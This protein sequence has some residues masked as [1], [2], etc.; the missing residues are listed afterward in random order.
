MFCW[1][2]LGSA[3][4]V[5]ITLTCATYLNIEADQVHPFVEM[6]FLDVS[7]PFQQN[8]APCKNGSR[9]VWGTQWLF[10]WPPHST[11]PKPIKHLWDALE[12]QVWSMEAPP[13]NLHNLKR[14]ATDSLEPDTTTYLQRSS[15]IHASNGTKLFWKQKGDLFIIRWVVKVMADQCIGAHMKSVPTFLDCL[16]QIYCLQLPYTVQIFLNPDEIDRI[17]C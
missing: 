13:H 12:K 11:D 9:M 7:G 15:G 5:D 16:K 2:T 8:N 10:T 3:I 14:S 4:H 17:H 6:V 1:E